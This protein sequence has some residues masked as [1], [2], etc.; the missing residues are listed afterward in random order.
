MISIATLNSAT[1]IT[2][3]GRV[4]SSIFGMLLLFIILTYTS[5]QLQG[6]Y[7]LVL[8]VVGIQLFFDLGMTTAV[9]QE[10][11]W[12]RANSSYGGNRGLVITGF[13][14]SALKL[15]FLISFVL[16]IAVYLYGHVVLSES[17]EF[18]NFYWALISLF[19]GLSYFT[20]GLLSIS[21]GF[22]HVTNVAMLT[23]IKSIINII[24]SGFFLYLTSD[25][26][27]SIFLGLL[28]SVLLTLFIFIYLYIDQLLEF[29]GSPSVKYYWRDGL[30]VFQTKL[31]I[32]WFSGYALTHG[33]VLYVNY[34][35][36]IIEAGKFGAASQI[37][38]YVASFIFSILSVS[39]TT[40]GNYFSQGE[41]GKALELFKNR[42]FFIFLFLTVF[43]LFFISIFQV[44]SGYNWFDLIILRIPD[45][46]S[47]IWISL[48]LLITL[49]NYS[50]SSFFR[51]LKE[52]PFWI[53]GIL[54]LFFLYSYLYLFSGD[55]IIL[56]DVYIPL[57]LTSL[58]LGLFPA[59]YLA[60]I[61]VKKL[62]V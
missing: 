25:I 6:Y 45:S 20:S 43:F 44:L 58:I 1:F 36:D 52:D 12:I 51:A 39:Q 14:F 37:I 35:F 50:L 53:F 29:R 15:Y 9:S 2:L 16:V 57:V 62:N 46:G 34:H 13:I 61:L 26:N 27:L 5:E 22:Q 48:L 17:N 3:L 10:L 47:F 42:V 31:M 18:N 59:L 24:V 7:Y 8:A 38:T 4:L 19:V 21:N 56:N 55:V 49:S 32:S 54:Q 23:S 60:K 33:M 30:L 40:I 11:A 41:T 28:S